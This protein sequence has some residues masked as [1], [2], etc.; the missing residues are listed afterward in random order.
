MHVK[1]QLRT[2]QCSGYYFMCVCGLRI[3]DRGLCSGGGLRYRGTA[4][5]NLRPV[6]WFAQFL[7]FG[8]GHASQ[9]NVLCRP[10]PSNQGDDLAFICAAVAYPQP[11]MSRFALHLRR[12][13]FPVVCA[14]IS[15]S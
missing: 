11:I 14:L 6:I 3:W 12:Y 4:W 10:D 5:E 1:R 2:A 9:K 15:C 8:P 13:Y 7:K